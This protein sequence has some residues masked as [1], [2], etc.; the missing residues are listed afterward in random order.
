LPT[1]FWAAGAGKEV[2]FALNQTL[3]EILSVGASVVE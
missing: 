2:E 1:N 3:T